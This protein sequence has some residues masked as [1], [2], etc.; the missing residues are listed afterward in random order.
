MNGPK[1]LPLL[2]ILLCLATP[3]LAVE[4][5]WEGA[6]TLP[7]GKLDVQIDLARDGSAWK[8]DITIPAQGARDLPLASIAVDAAKVSFQ[9]SGVPGTP[10]FNGT[11]AGNRI[12]GDFTQGGQT[13]PFTLTRSAAQDPAAALADFDAFINGALKP[14]DVPGIAIAVVAD[15]K[16]VYAKGF[17][18]RNVE[19]TLPMT[20]DTLL[21][22]G[23]ITK[24]F[25]TLA[26]GTLVD[27]GKLEWE[28]PVRTYLPEFLAADDV[29]TASLTVRDLVTHRSGLPRHDLV[30][31]NNQDLTRAEI[32]GR[33]AHLPASEGLRSRWQYN[34]LMFLT[35]GYLIED[36][37]GKPW[38][39]VIRSRVFTP[40]GMTRSNFKDE[41]S[42]KDADHARGYREDD[43]KILEMPFREVGNMG[44]AGSI[45][46]S[47]NEMANYALL[48]L[49]GGK[50]GG[51]TVVEAPTLKEMH[52]P[53]SVINALPDLPELSPT[54]YGMGWFIDSYRGHLR[55]AHGGNI[56]GFSA[57][58]TLFPNDGV[59]VVA[60]ANA[61][62]SGLPGIATS[63]LA[64]RMLKLPAKDWNGEALGR[65]AL[66]R[67]AADEAEKKKTATR[68]S[69]TKPSHAI[70]DYAG[71][72]E[73]PGYGVLAVEKLTG[74]KLQTTYNHI[75]T[76]LEHWHY[77]TFNGAKNEADP[78]FEDMK[79]NFRTDVAGNVF[80]VEASF[81][82]RVEPVLFRKRPHARLS[83]PKYLQPFLGDYELGP[84][85]IT[86]SLRGTKLIL[87]VANQRPYELEPDIDGWFNLAG[88][89]GFRARL[90][91]DTIE[92]SQPSGLFTATRKK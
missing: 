4:G 91:G 51:A 44:P 79:Y 10:T 29:L 27:E 11:V 39:D 32:V 42:A 7:T 20:A 60:L 37:T 40:L 56:D 35:A 5:R 13:F 6:I 34:N 72:Y 3:V 36:T 52:T 23:S 64:D 17:G 86:L 18:Q 54:T 15:G 41:D 74:D 88:L 47:V 68:K 76:P 62:G 43:G 53:Q 71:E 9:I 87:S 92:L 89:S 30:W 58:L 73:H 2:L 33:L 65:R 82:P 67:K 22:I 49:G 19:K 31:Y 66:A 28:K 84:Q 14:W 90:A 25:T 80:G 12:E 26:M 45:N 78:T 21:P 83:D 75:V 61:N 1:K 63:H 46:S 24:S 48:Q 16:V 81:E 77:D 8:G 85:K 69:G 70:A 55:V 59:A 38:E 57:L 50:F